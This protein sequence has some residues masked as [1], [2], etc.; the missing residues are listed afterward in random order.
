MTGIDLMK[1]AAT[2]FQVLAALFSI[3]FY[4]RFL[5]RGIQFF[6]WLLSLIVLAEFIGRLTYSFEYNVVVYNCLNIFLFTYLFYLYF[7]ELKNPLRKTTVKI[8]AFVFLLTSIV[9]LFIE[10]FIFQPL[11][12]NSLFGG[13]ALIVCIVLYFIEFLNSSK[14]I[15]AKSDLLF[16]ISTG[17]LL[18]YVGYIPIRIVRIAIANSLQNYSSLAI[19]HMLL[20]IILYGC[21]IIGIL[22]SKRN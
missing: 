11:I 13:F 19:V 17:Y 16:W 18:Y 8:L 7:N 9:N 6:P 12:W 2:A 22:C 15:H 1:F 10:N 21:L 5:V 20:N 14:V 4:K 3:F